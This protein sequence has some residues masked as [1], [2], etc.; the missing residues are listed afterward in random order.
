MVKIDNAVKVVKI[1]DENHKVIGNK[2]IDDTLKTPESYRTIPLRKEY[3]EVL[4]DFKESE[5]KRLGKLFREDNYVF[6]N[7]NG[8][9]YTPEI[10]T[11]KMPVFTEKW[12]LPHITPYGLRHSFA[13]L[14][15]KLGVKET[16]LKVMMGHKDI[17]TTHRYYIHLTDED[18]MEEIMNVVSDKS[19]ASTNDSTNEILMKKMDELMKMM[20]NNNLQ[21]NYLTRIA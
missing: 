15:A 13:S 12:G 11:N 14:M 20:K 9:P 4:K 7:R 10:L 8:E 6:L 21:N 18:I 19:T 17:S 1:Y 5:K 3:E 16:V 2:K